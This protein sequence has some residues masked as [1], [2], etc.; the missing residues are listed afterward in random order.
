MIRFLSGRALEGKPNRQKIR[1]MKHSTLVVFSAAAL[2]VSCGKSSDSESRVRQLEEENAR[3]RRAP[4]QSAALVPAA[5]KPTKDVLDDAVCDLSVSATGG[6]GWVTCKYTVTNDYTRSV[7]D[8]T[9]HIYEIKKE[10]GRSDGELLKLDQTIG[11]VK[12]GNAWY[13]RQWRSDE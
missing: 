3:L 8:E 2:S 12:R 13:H 10:L 9:F 7:K 6:T 4:G 5:E 11:F 1:I